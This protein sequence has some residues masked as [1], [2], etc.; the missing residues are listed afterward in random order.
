MCSKF[1]AHF[2]S[3]LQKISCMFLTFTIVKGCPNATSIPAMPSFTT[4]TWVA[5]TFISDGVSVIN[6]I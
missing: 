5:D 6:G 1:L 2:Y 4:A 3:C